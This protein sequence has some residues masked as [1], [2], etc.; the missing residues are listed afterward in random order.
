MRNNRCPN[1]LPSHN[2]KLFTRGPATRD[3][4]IPS[5]SRE[6]YRLLWKVWTVSEMPVLQL[7][8]VFWTHERNGRHGEPPCFCPS[9]F[10]RGRRYTMTPLST[11]QTKCGLPIHSVSPPVKA[12]LRK[13]QYIEGVT[14]ICQ[15]A[16]DKLYSRREARRLGWL[17]QK[18]FA[19][20][21]YYSVQ[22]I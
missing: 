16:T 5:V 3:H 6:L 21:R 11:T 14:N 15:R 12:S 22:S 17:N 19:T 7:L 13:R 9:A 1:P 4:P 2:S 8:A 20:R 18:I 10:T